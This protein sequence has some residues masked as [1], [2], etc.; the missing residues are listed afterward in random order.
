MERLH[1]PLANLPMLLWLGSL[2]REMLQGEL[3]ESCGKQLSTLGN[4]EV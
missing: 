3:E 4:A 2:R 1:P